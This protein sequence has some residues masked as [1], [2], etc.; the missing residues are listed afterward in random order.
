[1]HAAGGVD[2]GVLDGLDTVRLATVLAAK[3]AGAAVLD[4][5]TRDAGLD[6][7]VLFSSA[8]ATFGSSGQGNYAAATASLDALAQQRRARGLAALSVA[9]G[10][11]AGGGLAQ[12]SAAI[13]QR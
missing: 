1:M 10:P 7:F 13:R 8:A 2:D 6:A 12:A 3:A 5:L 4:E 9:W 11:W